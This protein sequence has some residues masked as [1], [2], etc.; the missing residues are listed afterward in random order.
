MLLCRTYIN[1][2]NGMFVNGEVRGQVYDMNHAGAPTHAALLND[3]QAGPSVATQATTVPTRVR[4]AVV[5]SQFSVRGD[6]RGST[7]ASVPTRPPALARAAP[8]G[9]A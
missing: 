9:L 6:L 4:A 5:L 8:C 3:L 2:Q 1:I 7:V